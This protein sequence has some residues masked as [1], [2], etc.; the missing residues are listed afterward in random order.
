[1]T[2]VNM[3]A[4]HLISGIINIP[5]FHREI[6][7]CPKELTEQCVHLLTNLG[8]DRDF[9]I[10]SNYEMV[11]F[12]NRCI[13]PFDD[14]GYM[15][16]SRH[17]VKELLSVVGPQHKMWGAISFVLLS[18]A[19]SIRYEDEQYA[20]WHR[21]NARFFEVLLDSG[22]ISQED[23]RRLKAKSNSTLSHSDRVASQVVK[24]VS[25][26]DPQRET[27]SNT[28][29][30]VSPNQEPPPKRVI[31]KD[32]SNS[33][34]VKEEISSEEISREETET[35]AETQTVLPLD[36]SDHAQV[37]PTDLSDQASVS[38]DS[39]DEL[40][41]QIICRSVKVKVRSAF[42]QNVNKR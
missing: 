31:I 7:T 6:T 26:V 4:L 1:M 28:P 2:Q 24:P 17:F 29:E 37:A 3:S 13:L 40:S 9:A 15:R 36:V 30:I 35:V 5:R 27:V 25:E 8:Q 22:V 41:P 10:K 20:V 18:T 12:L 34:Q 19:Q 16:V 42:P 38:E 11:E 33:P 32:R 14:A 23:E 39:T 21:L